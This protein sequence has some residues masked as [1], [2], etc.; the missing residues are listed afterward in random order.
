MNSVDKL[1]NYERSMIM[2]NTNENKG[3]F[4]LDYELLEKGIRK[5]KDSSVKDFAKFSAITAVCFSIAI[6]VTRSFGYF[7]TLGRF[8]VYHIDK[9][10][11]CNKLYVFSLI[12]ST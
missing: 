2:E 7:Y 8:S 1:F 3:R 4:L 9:S 11:T 5:I 10:Y 6:W 12:Y